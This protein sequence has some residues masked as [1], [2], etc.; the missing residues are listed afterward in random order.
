MAAAAAASS[1]QD[2]RSLIRS[3]FEELQRQYKHMEAMKKAYADESLGIIK[4]QK[5]M[6]ERMQADNST[7]KAELELENR[8]AQKK[9][10]RDSKLSSLHDQIDS[11]TM[12][13]EVEKKNIAT[14]ASNVEAVKAKIEALRAAVGGS[15]A[16]EENHKTQRKQTRIL[17]NRLDKALVKFNEVL[18]ENK[19][20]RQEIDDLRQERVVF[21]GIYRRMEGEL[22]ESK[23][24]MARIIEDSNQAYEVR[25]AATV[26]LMD[27]QAA[28][29]REAEAFDDEMRALDHRI[30]EEELAARALEESHRGAMSVAEEAA[31]KERARSGE[32]D[33]A[34]A[35]A[36]M[37][38]AAERAASYDSALRRV[39]E[40]TGI[41]SVDE[42]VASFVKGEEANFSLFNF[43][44]EQS[45]EIERIEDAI[46]DMRAEADVAASASG[47][48]ASTSRGVLRDLEG[49]LSA[50]R[51]A[52][53]KFEERCGTAQTR[54]DAVC[55]AVGRSYRRL[56][57]DERG[58][59]ALLAGATVTETNAISFLSVVEQRAAEL[60]EAFMAAKSVDDGIAVV[61]PSPAKP[62]RLAASRVE[63]AATAARPG[64]AAAASAAGGGGGG[65]F[66][67]SLPADGDVTPEDAPA[68]PA[69]LGA[70]GGG[71]AA[72]AEASSADG[73]RAGA[74]SPAPR[75]A[76]RAGEGAGVRGS[77]LHVSAQEREAAV[78]A[79]AS[80]LGPGPPSSKGHVRA[81]GRPVEA[82]RLRDMGAAD[83]GSDSDGEVRPLTTSELR[84]SVRK[85]RP[86]QR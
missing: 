44:A 57:C 85:L 43:I 36:A 52:V 53:S 9:A 77:A 38:E 81:T 45:S 27:L 14:L 17:E 68:S 63:P 71:T 24:A 31:L 7:L 46:A 73:A 4:K 74:G 62:A 66:L 76:G 13:S 3:E 5:E 26:Q 64:S 41:E 70:S 84:S 19:T 6:I 49:K 23:R 51:A 47:S 20:L 56:E 69:A 42:L 30:E 12:K 79:V 48:R 8:F 10:A 28:M 29:A 58:M 2:E 21:D 82:P 32:R 50:S 72:A 65:G 59:G 25:D 78:S 54:V 35:R 61:L 34:R 39:R 16:A 83:S 80:M 75:A 67:T 86:R 15:R 22:E 11:Y 55:A 40:A 1:D 18:A 33:L 37:T 60:I